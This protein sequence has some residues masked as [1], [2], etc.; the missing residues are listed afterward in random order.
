[1]TL[2]ARKKE[3]TREAI[4]AA[5]FG[6]FEDRG[7]EGTTIDQ[8]AR[9]ADVGRRTYFRY[10]RTKEAVVFP[11]RKK[12]FDRFQDL[13]ASAEPGE[14][15]P[16]A[17]VRRALL[18]LAEDYMDDG[19]WIRTR[20][21]IVEASPTLQAYDRE[22]DR[23]WEAAIAAALLSRE[24]AADERRRAAIVAGAVMGVIR[25]CLTEWQAGACRGDLVALG[26]EA[27]DLLE[28][29]VGSSEE[30]DSESVA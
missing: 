13:L 2:R 23:E 6:L 18:G 22:L 3:Q 24:P 19:A 30:C 29:G 12:R 25:A 9:E 7:F 20:L 14:E 11:E 1:M 26:R 16:F 27:V 17:R 15:T 8:I 4:V 10:F 21:L 5:A 28:R